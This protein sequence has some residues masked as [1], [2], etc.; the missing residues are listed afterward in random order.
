[1]ISKNYNNTTLQ[2][3]RSNID[4]LKE[5]AENTNREIF[6]KEEQ[7]SLSIY[8]QIPRYKTTVY[9]SENNNKSAIYALFNDPYLK[10]DSPNVFCG[11]FIT[12]PDTIKGRI[13]IRKVN[14]LDRLNIFRKKSLP[15]FLSKDI[16]ANTIIEY[17]NESDLKILLNNKALEQLIIKAVNISDLTR[18]TI[19]QLDTNFITPIKGE[20]TLGI[21]NP[22]Q[23]IIDSIYIEKHFAIANDISD[24]I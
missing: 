17:D 24:Y 21:I 16:I 10:T 14:T 23:W 20:T 18:V 9:I 8:R 4:I 2:E 7:Y 5:F 19:N 3:N 12:I 15:S 6:Y 22:Q 13:N 1:L 11:S